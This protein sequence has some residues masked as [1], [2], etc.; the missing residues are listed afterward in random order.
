[1]NSNSMTELKKRFPFL[2][3]ER[4]TAI[5]HSGSQQTIFGCLCGAT[6]STSTKWRGR[7]AVHVAV[8]RVAHDGCADGFAADPGTC[9]VMTAGCFSRLQR[10]TA[11]TEINPMT[12]TAAD[13][14]ARK[15]AEGPDAYLWCHSSGDVVLW[16][17][18]AS[19]VND[20]GVNAVE[21]WQVDAETLQHLIDS[22][23]VDE[24]A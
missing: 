24:V 9:A 16:A 21:R 17:D 22:G 19:S 14:I 18:E 13:I 23:D 20:S 5:V 3:R 4:A 10:A 8:W 15:H 1:M 12:T 7:D 6:H 11:Q 2:R